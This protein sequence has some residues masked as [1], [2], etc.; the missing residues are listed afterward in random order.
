[1]LNLASI[2]MID[3]GL[4]TDI[5]TDTMTPFDKY[6]EK[7]E[8]NAKSMGKEFNASEHMVDIFAQTIRRSNTNISLMGE[9]LKYSASI[10]AEAGADFDDLAVAIGMMA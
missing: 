1:M 10:S 2:G 6:L 3:L 9:T 7:V 4:A 8:K 5:L